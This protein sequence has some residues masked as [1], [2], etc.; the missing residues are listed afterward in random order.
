MLKANTAPNSAS[1][2]MY[3][4]QLAIQISW[5]AYLSDG[6]S[7]NVH[8]CPTVTLTSVRKTVRYCHWI[9][10]KYSILACWLRHGNRCYILNQLEAPTYLTWWTQSLNVHRCP[11]VTIKSMRQTEDGEILSL[12]QLEVFNIDLLIVARQPLLY[13]KSV[14]GLV[15][16]SLVSMFFRDPR[17]FGSLNHVETLD[18]ASIMLYREFQLTWNIQLGKKN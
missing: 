9:N 18:L 13:S 1:Q 2:S 10:L 16:W 6:Q 15:Q 12:N 8:R 3:V 7:L 4:L 14:R 17:A 11:T 5:K